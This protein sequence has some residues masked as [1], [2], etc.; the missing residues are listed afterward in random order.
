V[1]GGG[2]PTMF[3][4][5]EVPWL[6]EI[7]IGTYIFEDMNGVRDGFFKIEE[8]AATLLCTVAS[9]PTPDRVILDGGSKTL[10][11]EGGAPHGYVVEFPDAKIYAL[12][13]EHAFTNV[14]D[15][16]VKP[17]L[18]DRVRVIPNHVCVAVN[19][20][21]V[22]YGVRGDRVEAVWPIAARGLAQ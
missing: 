14:A 5:H 11:T 20:H 8:C 9:A 22:A 10:T 19:L 18:G 7:R 1:S 21:N 16:S 17:R 15:C 4:Q 2:S 6:T 3:Q 13:E 12:N